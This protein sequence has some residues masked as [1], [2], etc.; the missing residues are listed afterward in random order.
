MKINLEKMSDKELI[1]LNRAIVDHM[2]KRRQRRNYQQLAK[3]SPGDTVKFLDQEGLLIYGVIL[4][5]NKKTVTVH[6]MNPCMEWRLSPSLISHSDGNSKSSCDRTVVPL[7][8]QS[9]ENR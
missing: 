9:S 6:T 1:S 2:E 7:F 8:P 3:F 5:V 4:R